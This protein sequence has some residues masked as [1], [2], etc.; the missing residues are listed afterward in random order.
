[1]A[2]RHEADHQQIMAELRETKIA[3]DSSVKAIAASSIAIAELRTSI[4]ET[5]AIADS[6]ARAIGDWGFRTDDER[7]ETVDAKQVVLQVQIGDF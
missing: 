6:N 5:K 2:Q 4:A 1:M 3:T 7:A